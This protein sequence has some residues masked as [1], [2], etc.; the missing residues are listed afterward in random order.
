MRVAEN[1]LDL[2]GFTPMVQL[3]KINDTNVRIL[4]KLEYM[5]PIGS[6]K[7]RVSLNLIK[8]AEK[9][10]VLKPGMTIV[11]PTSGNTGMG[12]AM[13]ALL[14]GYKLVCTMPDKVS[15]DKTLLL[16]AHGAEVVICP[17]AVEPDDPRSYYSVASRIAEERNGYMP[18]QYQNPANPDTHYKSTGPEIWDQTEGNIDAFVCGVGTGGTISGIGK[19][20]KEQK[21]DVKIVG[22]DPEGS[23]I[24][25]EFYGKEHD[26]HTYVIEGIG[27]DL[28][29]GSLNINI[30]DDVVRV[31]DKETHLFCRELLLADGIFLGS[32]GAAAIL[33]ALRY[34][35]T[36]NGGTMVALVP[37]NGR[38][39]LTRVFND[40]WMR[41][42]DF[43]D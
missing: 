36:M 34:A 26:V 24:Y 8:D 40:D 35:K 23:M 10:G 14:K 9:R 2:I 29:P 15:P 21:P 12:L 31:A 13:V 28:I 39:Y 6:I 30:M 19:Y 38:N 17:T 7:D 41:E 37:D 1:L 43:L 22:V 32:S 20:L 4:V 18:N 27:E 42:K 11:E 33:G 5:N 25:S 16:Q 3:N